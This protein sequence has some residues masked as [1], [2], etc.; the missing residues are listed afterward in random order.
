MWLKGGKVGG[1][2]PASG[3]TRPALLQALSWAIMWADLTYPPHEP[4]K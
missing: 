1:E 2:G 3:E 4:V